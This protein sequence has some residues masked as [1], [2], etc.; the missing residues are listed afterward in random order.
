[1]LNEYSAN[2]YTL[3]NYTPRF[4]ESCVKLNII[5]DI[6]FAHSCVVIYF[7]LSKKVLNNRSRALCNRFR[8][9]AGQ[10]TFINQSI[11]NGIVLQ[12]A[13]SCV[14]V[15]LC[16]CRCCCFLLLVFWGGGGVKYAVLQF[17]VSFI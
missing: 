10:N 6:E 16:F 7:V 15:F 3:T 4:D 11:M 13:L 14:C 1:M 2:M 5:N 8:W 17:A 12:F 9:H